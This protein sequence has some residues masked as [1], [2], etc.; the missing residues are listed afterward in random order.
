[1]SKRF[2][3][4]VKWFSG[5]QGCGILAREDEADVFVRQTPESSGSY[6]PLEAGRQVEFSIHDDPEGA[7]ATDVRVI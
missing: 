1:M 2:V 5:S 6:R 3:G 7:Y 4:T